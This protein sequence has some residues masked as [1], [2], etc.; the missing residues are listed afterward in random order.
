MSTGI[1][2][3]HLD[4]RMRKN[5][6]FVNPLLEHRK[7]PPGNPVPEQHLA[8][9]YAA[10]DQALERMYSATLPVNVPGVLAQ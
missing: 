5:G 3:P 8:A 9:F 4:F 2:G 6:T 7:L 10:R 1:A